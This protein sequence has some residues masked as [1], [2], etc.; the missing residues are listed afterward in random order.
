MAG[1]MGQAMGPQ[2]QAG[3]LPWAASGY[4]RMLPWGPVLVTVTARGLMSEDAV[5]HCAWGIWVTAGM[6]CV[7]SLGLRS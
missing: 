3:V 4:T 6:A 5:C 7:R 2:G 1:M